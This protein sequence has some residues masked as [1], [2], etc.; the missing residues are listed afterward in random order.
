[1]SYPDVLGVCKGPITC[2]YCG[3]YQIRLEAKRSR[4]TRLLLC[5]TGILLRRLQVDPWLASVSHVFVDEVC[6]SDSGRFGSVR[7]SLVWIGFVLTD[8]VV[9]GLVRFGSVWFGSVRFSPHETMDRI[10]KYDRW[11][12]WF[13]SVLFGSAYTIPVVA[14]SDR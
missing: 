9:F 3:R 5:T 7:I 8:L 11:S 12:R 10:P 4:G 14:F 6:G 2:I 13:G 1:M